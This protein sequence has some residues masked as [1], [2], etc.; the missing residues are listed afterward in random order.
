[1][2]GPDDGEQDHDA[3]RDDPRPADLEPD[4]LVEFTGEEPTVAW[5]AWW[6]ARRSA[7]RPHR[8]SPWLVLA[9]V[10]A[11]G[12]ATGFSVT[13]L[14]V[15]LPDVASSL[16]AAPS[17]LVFV[18]TGPFLAYA[19]AMPVLGKIGDVH[20]HRRV[21]LLGLAG[22]AVAT[23]ASAFA[24]DAPSLIVLRT[25]AALAGAA[26]GP[27]SMAMI[28]HAF[29][30][31]ER[32]KAIGWWSLVAGAAP[33]LGLVAGGPLVDAV[34]WR[35]IFA[36]Q[37]P[38][39]AVA[40]VI[41]AWVL[42][43]TA[44]RAR[45]FIDWWGAALLALATV[46]GLGALQLVGTVGADPVLLVLLALAAVAGFA[47]V[48]I[49]RRVEVP[50]IP[51]GLLRTRNFGASVAAQWLFSFAYMGGYIVTPVLVQEVFGL[52]VAQAS[53]AM[54]I[55][56]LVFAVAAPVVGYV[57]VNV[58]ER[59]CAVVGSVLL[60]AAMGAF[61]AGA[62]WGVLGLVL[63]GLALGGLANGAASPSL[64]TVAA[65]AIPHEDLGVGNAAQQMIAQIG[66]VAG[67]QAM[68]LTAVGLGGNGF[69]AAFVVGG[70][71]A[72]GAVV[73]AAGLRDRG[74]ARPVLR[75]EP[76]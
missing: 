14:T 51:P 75:V 74:A 3:A 61:L 10:M 18:V 32:A 9:V 29:V 33:V 76:A 13:I 11:G 4:L 48:R 41:A 46:G 17:E 65:N 73:A 44:R 59:R 21:Y 62:A 39:A 66:A 50:L 16:D 6:R 27:A 36:V 55:R 23:G 20:G 37:A 12:F 26:T 22:F 30:P 35:A 15:S 60:V 47:F 57:A 28:M 63:A 34:G 67:M 40:V 68:S 54:V 56:P 72:A 69:S 45:A 1:V 8:R 31:A 7:P 38:L 24:W 70:I 58:G 52:S 5:P 19:L 49:E 71:A 25:V 2:K 64:V 43:E 42:P 53:L